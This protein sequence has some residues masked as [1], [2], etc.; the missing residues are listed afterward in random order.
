MTFEEFKIARYIAVPGDCLWNPFGFRND[1]TSPIASEMS[2]HLPLLEYFATK[3]NHITEFG[4]RSCNS[5]VAFIAGAK[6]KVVSYDIQPTPAIAQLL[7]MQNKGELPCEWEFKCSNTIA[8][9]L[10]IENTDFLFIDTLHTYQQ[11]RDELKQGKYVNKWI[12]F[13]DVYS[14]GKMSLDIPGEE[15]INRAIKEFLD[16]NKEWKVI[17]QVP[18]NHG[19]LIIENK[20]T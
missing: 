2:A 12:G 3:C 9:N 16:E 11:V 6:K 10:Q 7:E 17:Y 14:Q 18:F 1:Y 20:G 13:H 4:T 8:P 19:L 15:G 5:T